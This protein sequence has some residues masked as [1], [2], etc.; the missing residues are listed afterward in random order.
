MDVILFSC[1]RKGFF[2]FHP[3]FINKI[4]REMIIFI[5]AYSDR[6]TTNSYSFTGIN[7]T[8]YIINR[9]MRIVRNCYFDYNYYDRCYI[10]IL[11]GENKLIVSGFFL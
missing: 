1:F 11:S 7:Q 6:E 10:S 8:C 5:S 9:K 2:A 4:R 3:V